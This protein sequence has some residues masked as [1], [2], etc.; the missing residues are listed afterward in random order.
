MS[1]LLL[2]IPIPGIIPGMIPGIG[3]QPHAGVG[4]WVIL[5]IGAILTG[6]PGDGMGDVVI[7]MSFHTPVIGHLTTIG[8]LIF[9]QDIII[10]IHGVTRKDLSIDDRRCLPDPWLVGGDGEV[11]HQLQKK[12]IPKPHAPPPEASR[13]H[14]VQGD[15]AANPAGLYEGTWKVKG[16]L[17]VTMPLPAKQSQKEPAGIHRT[18]QQLNQEVRPGEAV[19]IRLNLPSPEAHVPPVTIN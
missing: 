11:I 17:P 12:L 16:L 8:I 18:D 4:M 14:M 15:R 10:M 1:I 19:D 2:I 9:L 13:Q 7:P 6:I 3:D 5:T